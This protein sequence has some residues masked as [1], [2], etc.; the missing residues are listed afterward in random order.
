[1]E[2]LDRDRERRIPLGEAVEVLGDQQRR[3]DR[4]GD[5]DLNAARTAISVLPY[6]TS[7]QMRRSIGNL[8]LHAAL[9]S[10]IDDVST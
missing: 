4:D 5:A 3:G 8:L 1:V 2:R 6:P 7:P 9:T 10:S